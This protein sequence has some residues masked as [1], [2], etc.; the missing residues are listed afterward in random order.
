M[1]KKTKSSNSSINS[2][3]KNIQSKGL[4]GAVII[5]LLGA[6][7]LGVVANSIDYNQLFGSDWSNVWSGISGQK[8]T[9]QIDESVEEVVVLRSVDGDT[10]ELKDGRKIR[11]LN[12]DTPETVKINTPVMCYGPEAKDVSKKLVE[13]KTVYIVPD[14]EKTDR[15]GRELRFIYLNVEDAKAKKIEASV[16]SILVQKGY[17]QAKAYSPN[18]TYKKDFEKWMLQAQNEKLGVW[19]KCD[20]P[21]IN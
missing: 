7:G 13:G 11:F 17:A 1:I 3:A 10:V 19:G 4:I 8:S 6:G 18:T 21:F 9:K 20:K 12:M 2:F 5:S 14:K 15:Y 16:N